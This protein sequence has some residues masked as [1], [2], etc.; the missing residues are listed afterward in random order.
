MN[1]LW[2]R[3]TLAFVA[4]TLVGVFSVAVLADISASQAF[5]RYVERQDVMVQSGLLD[6]LAR[7]YQRTGSWNGVEEVFSTGMGGRGHG[8]QRGR[9]GLLLVDS[10]GT[11]VYDEHGTRRGGTLTADEQTDALPI[12]ANGKTV[13]FLA[14]LV[15]G[16]GTIPQAAQQF[17]DQ[18][19]NTLLMVALAIS[20]LGILLGLIISRTLAA[21]LSKLTLAARSIAAHD[22][23]RRVSIG[24]TDEVAEVGRAFNEM[25]SELE[26]SEIVRRNL[27]ADIAHELRT[28]L[29][30]MQGNLQAMLDEVYP[31]EHSEIAI[32]YNETRILTRLVDDLRELSLADAGHLPLKLQSINVSAA[33][34]TVIAHFAM[35]AQEQNIRL[36]VRAGDTLPRVRADAD[37]LAQIL[38]NLLANAL[39]HT[40]D[41]G[42]IRLMAAPSAQ[43]AYLCISVSDTGLGIA[44]DDLAH[45]FERFYR[46]EK[47][48]TRTQNSTGLGLAICKAWVEAM[49]GEI[50]VESVVGQGS[51][52]WFTLPFA[53]ETM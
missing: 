43:Q 4:I 10:R 7:F 5:R 36:E 32:L 9:P 11:I 50:G 24:G 42:H 21:P 40:P 30:V 52:F 53:E 26:R 17:L 39:R 8:Q 46:V 13:G 37:R 33:L 34:Q 2:L 22:W 15:P 19:R 31:L 29:T 6:N 35:A 45:I 20:S 1:R 41:G 51:R 44:Q 12:V 23:Q 18:L 28:P 38:R 16:D 27:I 49:G 3:L 48:R 47:A 25:A 14:V